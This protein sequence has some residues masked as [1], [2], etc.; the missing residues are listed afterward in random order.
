MNKK[1]AIDLY[2]KAVFV[3]HRIHIIINFQTTHIRRI[4]LT[5]PTF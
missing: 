2:T 5:T 1:I 4:M 3:N